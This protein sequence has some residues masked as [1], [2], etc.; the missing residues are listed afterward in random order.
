MRGED[1][2]TSQLFSYLSPDTLVPA[3][4]PLRPIRQHVNKAL[5]ALSPAFGLLYADGGRPSIAPEK[6]LRA[7]LLQAFFS[8][9]SERQLMEQLTYNMM[10]RWFVGLS[11]DVTVWDVTVFTKNRDRLLAGEIA[12]EFLLAVINAP[13]VKPLLS[14]EHFSVDGTLIEAWASMKSFKPKGGSN[15]GPPDDPGNA[16]VDFRGQRRRND[17][18]ESTTDPES[19]LLRKSRGQESKLCFAGHAQIGRAHV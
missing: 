11:M 12:R 15:E 1:R 5:D 2:Q 7:L 10:F 18:H 6:L 13:E 4:H 9:R 19:R 14:G 17:T 3:T 8:I 16:T